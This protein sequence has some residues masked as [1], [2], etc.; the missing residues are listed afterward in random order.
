MELR[1]LKYFLA[2]AREENFTR[3]AQILHVT[4][5]T[6]SRQIAQLEE[7]LGVELFTRSNHNIILTEDGMILKRRAQEMLAL[8]EKT[9]QDLMHREEELAGKIT[10]GSGEF[11]STGVLAQMI[12]GFSKKHPLVQ[13]EIY[14]GNAD[15]IHDYIERGFLDIGLM[16]EPIDIRKYDFIPMTVKEKW[17]AWVRTDSALSE[18]EWIQPEDLMGERLIVATGDFVKSSIGQ[19]MGNYKEQAE[20]IAEGNLLYNEM[21]LAESNLG[22]VLGIKLNYTYKGIRFVP[23]YPALETSTFLAWKK[24][25]VFTSATSAFLAYARQYEKVISDDKL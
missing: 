21:M 17:G 23:L 16:A 6:L 2:V 25:Q 7:E 1:V 24:E 4:Q 19:W 22:I 10:I 18:K 13:Y 5:P 8:A 3:A 12:A 9:R 20:I 15:N 11:Q 14:S